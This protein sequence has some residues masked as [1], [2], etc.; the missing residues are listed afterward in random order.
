MKRL[1][2]ET[3]G[4]ANV[5]WGR[6]E[7][8]VFAWSEVLYNQC[9]RN[10]ANHSYPCCTP[11]VSLSYTNGIHLRF[12]LF[13]IYRNMITQYYM[14]SSLLEITVHKRTFKFSESLWQP[15]TCNHTLVVNVPP[16]ACLLNRGF[17]LAFN[18]N[19]WSL[20]DTFFLQQKTHQISRMSRVNRH[21]HPSVLPVFC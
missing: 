12:P 10:C 13:N 8:G 21:S 14:V 18:L 17:V 6:G 15:K 1:G 19:L 16:H 20:I 5:R 9:V 4:R 3:G 2:G 11:V 7:W